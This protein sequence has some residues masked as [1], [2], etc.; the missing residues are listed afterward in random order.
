M[1]LP[2]CVLMATHKGG[3]ALGLG[4]WRG[5]SLGEMFSLKI[6][7]VPVDRHSATLKRPPCLLSKHSLVWAVWAGVVKEGPWK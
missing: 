4:P 7:R 1:C 3:Q 2:T 6:A 5:A